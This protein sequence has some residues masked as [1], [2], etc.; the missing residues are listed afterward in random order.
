M[1]LLSFF[2]SLTSII[3]YL[4]PIEAQGKCSAYHE[5]SGFDVP[6]AISVIVASMK[7]NGIHTSDHRSDFPHKTN[8]EE[9]L[10]NV[11]DKATWR[12]EGFTTHEIVGIRYHAYKSMFWLNDGLFKPRKR[13]KR[14]WGTLLILNS[15]SNNCG[16]FFGE[17]ETHLHSYERKIIN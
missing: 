7:E 13:I 9:M 16:T 11:Y 12:C 3:L 15:E 2:L 17:V 5:E 1:N 8:F 10:D 6:A 14:K 4:F